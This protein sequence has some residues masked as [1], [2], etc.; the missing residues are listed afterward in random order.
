MSKK[1]ATLI[2]FFVSVSKMLN[3]QSMDVSN[4]LTQD[5]KINTVIVVASIIL[6]G[7]FLFL[8]YIERKVKK[9]EQE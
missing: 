7:I 3:A 9:L 5:G 4:T 1:Y 2:L 6:L 8:F